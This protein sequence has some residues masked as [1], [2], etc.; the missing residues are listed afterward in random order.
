METSMGLI[1]S[2]GAKAAQLAAAHNS[3]KAT[4]ISMA[5]WITPI[6]RCG[7]ASLVLCDSRC[8]QVP[9]VASSWLRC[10]NQEHWYLRHAVWLGRCRYEGGRHARESKLRG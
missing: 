6:W 5:M 9:V 10:R 8:S 1:T 2:F 3:R 7:R 4:P